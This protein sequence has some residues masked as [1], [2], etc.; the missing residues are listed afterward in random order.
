M[1]ALSPLVNTT[2]GPVRGMIGPDGIGIWRGI[3]YATPPLGERRWRP[4]LP[5]P[6]WKQELDATADGPGCPQ[7]C[8]I[9]GPACPPTTDENCLHLNVF[10]PGGR[11][12]PGLK[13]VLFWIHGGDFVQG[14]SGGPL[15]DGTSFAR[16]HDV[17]VIAAN[18]RLGALGFLRSGDDDLKGEFA[19]NFGLL[20]QR[21]AMEWARDNAARFGG[22]P[23]A[24]TI[25]GQS[26]GGMS[27][28]SHLTMPESAPLFHRAI[29]ESDP[30]GLPF[31]TAEEYPKFARVV[32]RKAGCAHRLLPFEPF[33]KCMRGLSPHAV[34]EAQVAAKKDLL[35]EIGHFFDLFVPYSPAVNTK[36]LA[37][38][39]LAAIERG[40]WHDKPVVIGSVANEG[41][42]FAY[43]AFP[44]PE[45][46]TVEDGLLA[47]GF[48]ASN[49]VEILRQYPRSEASKEAHD[50][51]N[52]TGIIATDGL[53]H[54]A[55]R[56]AARNLAA[57][58][59]AGSRTSRTWLYHFD[60]VVSFGREMWLPAFP[61]CLDA[62]CH[63][64]ELPFVWLA[65]SS[66]AAF[67]ATFTAPEAALAETMQ[68]YWAAFAKG[69]APLARQEVGAAS[70]PVYDAATEVMMRFTASPPSGSD[71]HAWAPKCK[72][73]DQLNYTWM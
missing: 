36:V 71:R 49:S 42:L 6:L 31:R 43:Q 60:H 33:E 73:W 17:V 44:S 5:H 66:L 7:R 19:G 55:I 9:Q 40:L 26:A 51:R 16:D 25:F 48:G 23:G 21:L 4:P 24:V 53:F 52:H 58:A 12:G 68:R 37:M 46:R 14:Y 28:A 22:D 34:V 11:R 50:V 47:A 38:Q 45:S 15:Y 30:L 69:G 13:Q 64:E 70:W 1:F 39:P 8:E 27:I 57:Q 54:C 2:Y 59:R 18:Y 20:D 41:K 29:V 61:E 35:V 10:S 56:H 3:P 63:S 65:N 67:N 72:F 62:A 32:A